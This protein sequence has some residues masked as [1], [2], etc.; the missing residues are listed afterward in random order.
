MTTPLIISPSRS[1]KS[2]SKISRL[3]HPTVNSLIHLYGSWIFDCCLLQI[4][5]RYSR[6]SI[7]DCK[8][9]KSYVNKITTLINLFLSSCN[10]I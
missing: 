5:D 4:K 6:S 3:N 10:Q 1:E 9:I 8:S 2:F 7:N